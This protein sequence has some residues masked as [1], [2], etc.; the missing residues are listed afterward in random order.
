MGLA[1]PT[2]ARYHLALRVE[3]QGRGF[4]LLMSVIMFVLL[5]GFGPPTMVDREIAPLHRVSVGELRLWAEAT[6]PEALSARAMVVEA[7]LVGAHYGRAICLRTRKITT[8]Q[9]IN[10]TVAVTASI[11]RAYREPA[12]CTKRIAT[13]AELL[14]EEA[15]A[16]MTNDCALARSAALRVLPATK[17]KRVTRH[18]RMS[19]VNRFLSML[20][21]RGAKHGDDSYS[22]HDISS[23]NRA[24]A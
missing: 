11:A 24:R 6:S 17:P 2:A 18:R 3:A 22:L 19:L 4:Y 14:H 23:L 20:H 15:G 5:T 1:C 8:P 21:H 10:R 12:L 7:M 16:A 13:A 9:A